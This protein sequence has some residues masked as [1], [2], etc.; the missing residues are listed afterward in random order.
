MTELE[1][2]ALLPAGLRDV[3]PNDAAFEAEIV[4]RLV[5]FLAARGYDRVKPPLIEFEEGL[6]SGAGV[7]VAP[8][9]F[10]LMD[11]VSQRMMGLR[12]DITPQIARIATSR[13]A[14][15]PRPLRLSYAG[16]VLRVRGSQLRPERQIVQ[17]G[18]ELIGSAAPTADAEIIVMA[19]EAIAELGV[20][21]LSVDL[22]VPRLVPSIIDQHELT[23]EDVV[24]VR[25]ALDRKDSGSV[26]ALAGPAAATLCALLATTG[27]VDDALE[28]LDE[29]DLPDLAAAERARVAVVV[30]LVRRLS[31]D[32]KLTL[33]PVEHRGFEYHTGIGFTVFA[34]GASGDLA[35]GGRYRT[36]HV[37]MGGADGERATGVTLYVDSILSVLS[38]PQM[39]RRVLIPYDAAPSVLAALRKGGWVTVMALE[40]VKHMAAEA[41][42]LGCSHFLAETGPEPIQEER[43]K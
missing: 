15:T 10:R 8:Q 9:T 7:A 26:S 42:R 14:R 18:A 41:K 12:A 23:E 20:G 39:P 21:G 1:R 11:P 19:I 22:T 37:D 27:P 30:D 25:A 29:I 28:K 5:A 24:T 6:L 17:V 35:T 34:T 32:I 31:P 38:P 2:N 16:E 13:L 3:L 43:D 33:D 4:E 36:R 40:A